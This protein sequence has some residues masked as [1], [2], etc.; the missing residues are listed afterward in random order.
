MH[1]QSPHVVVVGNQADTMLRF[2][3][4]L[5]THLIARGAKVTV[6]CPAGTPAERNAIRD[7]GVDHVI[8]ERMSRS[9]LNP[10]HDLR[11]LV[12]LARI[13]RE[14]AP[15]HVMSYFLK[16]AV[17]GTLAAWWAGVPRRIAMIEGLG[18]AFSGEAGRASRRRRLARA[19]VTSLLRLALRKAHKVIV[20]NRDDAALLRDR[21]GV[22]A[23]RIAQIDGIG[24]DMEEFA[25]QPPAGPPATFCLAARLIREKGVADFV[26]AARAIKQDAPDT[27]FIL[28]GDVDGSP[29]SISRHEV[30]QWVAAGLVSWP[31]K[32]E[33]VRPYYARSS[34]FVLPSFYGEGLPR[35]IMEAMAMGR[36][37]VTTTAPGCRDSVTDGVSGIIIPPND[38]QALT[39]A[40][41]RFLE[42]PLL[43]ARLGD[44][45]A[46]EARQRYDHRR[47]DALVADLILGSESDVVARPSLER[48][49]DEGPPESV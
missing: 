21:C 6:L 36:A 16:P 2:R 41:R 5:L 47:Q 26:E 18:F 13:M 40:L 10:L 39:A 28:L 38:V 3:G 29:N 14:R 12:E 34:A 46:S 1:P 9:S 48:R 45:A 27:E 25:Q 33:D 19:F 22:P 37:V 15:G 24:V 23:T 17:Y 11:L 35:S 20:L 44:A 7:L 4:T 31:G 43:A 8:V 49:L 42:D 32:V 30:E